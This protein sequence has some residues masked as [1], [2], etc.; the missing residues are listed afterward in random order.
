MRV[1]EE[2]KR[3]LAIF[4]QGFELKILSQMSLRASSS[5]SAFLTKRYSKTF[6]KIHFNPLLSCSK[7][8]GFLKWLQLLISGRFTV[9]KRAANK[10]SNMLI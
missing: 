1:K 10:F 2:T 6:L 8:E 7:G 4:P 3:R 5:L 9:C